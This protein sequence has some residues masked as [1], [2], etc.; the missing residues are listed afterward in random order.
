MQAQRARVEGLL[1]A[2][3]GRSSGSAQTNATGLP[4]DLKSGIETLS[5]V[6]MDGV[7]VHYNSPRPAQLDALAY[8]QGRSIHLAPRQ[9]RHLPHEAWH[10]VQQS[11]GRVK[12]TTK[13]GGVAI[14]DD[15]SLERQADVM[16]ARA[17]RVTKSSRSTVAGAP[18]PSST[19]ATVQR[20]SAKQGW[21]LPAGIANHIFDGEEKGNN[22]SGLHSEA[23]KSPGKNTLDYSQ[24]TVGFRKDSQPYGAK[25]RAKFGDSWSPKNGVYKYSDM[26]P[27]GWDENKVTEAIEAAYDSTFLYR[28]DGETIRHGDHWRA[29]KWAG[30]RERP[31]HRFRRASARDD[32]SEALIRADLGWLR[33]PRPASEG[34]LRSGTPLD[35]C[36]LQGPTPSL[37]S[38]RRMPWVRSSRA[39]VLPPSFSACSEA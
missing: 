2:S 4:A 23:R 11:E 13:F 33:E 27:T 18:G 8:A 25:V 24:E 14:N 7:Q 22:L 6:S 32:L 21:S 29:G 38:S 39:T 3:A 12:P 9:E 36:S 19:S 28:P 15:P 17:A 34:D 35:D 10:L 5:G 30:Q 20:L 37:R 16:G 1:E 26:F 31:G